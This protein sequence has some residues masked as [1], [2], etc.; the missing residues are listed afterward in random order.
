M[1]RASIVSQPDKAQEKWCLALQQRPRVQGALVSMEPNTGRIR[2]LIGGYSFSGSQFNRAV[3]A[4]RQPGS[5]FKPITYAAALK[6]GYTAASRL[7]DAPVVLQGA[8]SQTA[9][10]PR[11]YSL[12]IRGRV[13]LRTALVHSINRATIRLAQEIGTGR[14]ID[15]AKEMGLQGPF[16]RNLTIAIGSL[17]VSPL[18]LTQAYTAFAR[19]G[20]IIEPTLISRIENSWGRTIHKAD[21]GT[22]RALSPQTTFIMTELL[23]QVVRDGTGWRAKKLDRPVAG[24]TGTTNNQKEGW[25]AG[26]TPNLLTTVYCGFDNPRPMGK[27][28][29]GSRAASPIWVSYMRKVVSE[30]PN[31]D[32]QKPEGIVMAQVAAQSGKVTESKSDK[33]FL[34]PFRKGKVP[35]KENTDG[36]EKSQRLKGIF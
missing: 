7:M 23:R 28:E 3:Q 16:P 13:L 8:R 18:S 34:L 1:V 24:K 17:D 31:R 35:N 27:Y 22:R 2:A 5:A 36:V 21:P 33:S 14:I 25:F 10:K 26:Y 30:Y 19:D 9:W 4:R 12:H 32:F 6:A 15:Q 11:N 29:T 20:T